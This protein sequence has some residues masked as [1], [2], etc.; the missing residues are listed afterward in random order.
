MDE[1]QPQ[2]SCWIPNELEITSSPLRFSPARPVRASSTTWPD[3]TLWRLS[4]IPR[5]G[6]SLPACNPVQVLTSN[7]ACARQG[8]AHVTIL[9]PPVSDRACTARHSALNCK[10]TMA[11][12]RLSRKQR[13]HLPNACC[14]QSFPLI[15][16]VGCSATC[17]KLPHRL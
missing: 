6:K 16:L 8:D 5:R 4:C 1:F 13:A 7:K 15:N 10:E 9:D 11:D 2:R 14:K 17:D 12:H 3:R